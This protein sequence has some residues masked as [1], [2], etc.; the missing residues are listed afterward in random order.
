MRLSNYRIGLLALLAFVMGGASVHAFAAGARRVPTCADPSVV[1]Y[2]D[3]ELTLSEVEAPIVNQL[4][5]LRSAAVMDRL[6]SELLEEEAKH[7]GISP[8]ELLKQETGPRLMPPSDEELRLLHEQERASNPSVP[9]DLQ[10]FK[11]QLL[12][13]KNRAE[14]RFR[15]EKFFDELMKHGNARLNFD[16]L[17]RPKLRLRSGG[18]ALGPDDARVTI[19]EYTDFE[20]SFGAQAQPTVEKILKEFPKDVRMVFR[21]NPGEEHPG[22]MLA[23]QAALCANDQ[24]RYW[25]Y[26]KLLFS[27]Q[28]TFAAEQLIEFARR[29]A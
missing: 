25:D 6:F 22:A 19:V 7:R 8:D 28:R 15:Q 23:A 3:K 18:P 9:A 12:G 4:F 24:E 29:L 14:E 11:V 13:A 2:L 5:E 17:G 16:A 27:E 21:Q 1:H 26:R 10:Q 20:S